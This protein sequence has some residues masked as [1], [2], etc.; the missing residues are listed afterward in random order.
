MS[1]NELKEWFQKN[2][3]KSSS[4]LFDIFRDIAPQQK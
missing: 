4:K 3:N 2:V 1:F